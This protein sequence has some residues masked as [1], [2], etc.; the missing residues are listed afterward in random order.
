M[1]DVF[2]VMHNHLPSLFFMLSTKTKNSNRCM[3][4]IFNAEIKFKLGLGF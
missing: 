3:M 1:D 4:Q 2:A